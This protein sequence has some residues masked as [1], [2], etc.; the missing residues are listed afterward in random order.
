MS[1]NDFDRFRFQEAIGDMGAV[2][3]AE[4]LGCPKSLISMYLS[5]QRKPSK[6]A[7]QLISLILGVNPAWLSGLDVSKESSVS[8]ISTKSS[9]SELLDIYRGV[10]EQ[11]QTLIVA[12][13]KLIA[14]MDEYKK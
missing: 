14:S 9:E 1:Q 7:I 5:G 8:I 10:N 6:M 4:K 2:N 13:A 11:G 3:L 12:N